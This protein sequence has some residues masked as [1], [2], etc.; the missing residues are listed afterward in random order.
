MS[1]SRTDASGVKMQT[2]YRQHWVWAKKH[3]G[4]RNCVRN[5]YGYAFLLLDF[6][7]NRRRRTIQ[8]LRGVNVASRPSNHS[9]YESGHDVIEMIFFAWIL[10]MM[11]VLQ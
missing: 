6:S 9:A 4:V 8:H 10:N 11:S 7:M 1:Q 3:R 2:F 5:A